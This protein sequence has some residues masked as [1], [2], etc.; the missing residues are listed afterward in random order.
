[1]KAYSLIVIFVFVCCICGYTSV[2]NMPELKRNILNFGYRINFKYEGMIAHSF[3]SFHV[4]MKFVLLIRKDIRFLS[5]EFYSTHKYLNFDV[6]RK[7]FPTQFIPN[8]KNYCRKNIPFIDFYK[9]QISSYNHTVH[10][11][12]T[13]EISL[14]LPSF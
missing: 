8:F 12:L 5:M 7:H 3:D 4:E 1:M 10:K 6:D 9:K 11:I 2:E 14:L 13:K